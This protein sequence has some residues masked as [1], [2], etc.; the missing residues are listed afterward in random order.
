MIQEMKMKST[1]TIH[2]LRRNAAFPA[3]VPEPPT[4]V[5][6]PADK[7]L[8]ADSPPPTVDQLLQQLL[9]LNN[10]A[11]AGLITVVL[12]RY[13]MLQDGV[14]A[15]SDEGGEYDV[16]GGSGSEAGGPAA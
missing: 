5:P 11:L 2:F 12:E 8:G 10:E 13:P 16:T 9:A 7:L 1:L 14:L 4:A 6:E 15:P 3:P